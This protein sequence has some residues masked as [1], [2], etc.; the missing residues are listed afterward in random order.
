M[1]LQYICGNRT[2]N[3]IPS[4]ALRQ[5]KAYTHFLCSS[6]EQRQHVVNTERFDKHK[7][8]AHHKK[9]SGVL[10]VTCGSPRLGAGSNCKLQRKINMSKQ[11]LLTATLQSCLGRYVQ[12]I[13]LILQHLYQV[14]SPVGM[15]LAYQLSY[16]LS[17]KSQS[18]K[19]NLAKH[20]S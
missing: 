4:P 18:P 10:R 7:R 6:N 5:R 14:S 15:T 16:L 12:V 19:L 20:Q 11:L 13:S 2:K 1:E 17:G 8:T 9:Q 3:L